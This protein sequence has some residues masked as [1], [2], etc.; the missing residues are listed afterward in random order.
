MRRNASQDGNRSREVEFDNPAEYSGL[1]KLAPVVPRTG[2]TPEC[3]EHEDE[4]VEVEMSQDLYDHVLEALYTHPSLTKYDDN[5]N[6]D[7]P[8]ELKKLF[9]NV[10]PSFL[11]VARKRR[12]TGVSDSGGSD[13]PD[14]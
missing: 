2:L 5:D 10:S 13:L 7:A 12:C 14:A 11:T 1:P 3:Q 4:L 9:Q 6:H 8:G